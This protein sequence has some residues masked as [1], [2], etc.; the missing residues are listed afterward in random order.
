MF[1]DQSLVPAEAIRLAALGLL[2]E[3]ER[4]YADLAVEVRH[5]VDRVLGPSL[6]SLGPSLELLRYEGLVEA[7]DGPP[8]AGH[9]VDP[10]SRLRLTEAG[11]AMLTTLLAAHVRTPINDVGKLVIA[12][13]LRFLH[14]LE[15]P[16]RGAELDRLAGAIAAERA[17]LADLRTSQAGSET[18]LLA[19]LDREIA[20]AD[21][22]TTWLRSLRQ[23]L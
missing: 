16:A 17:R 14:L 11:G 3:R 1:R 10:A 2:A 21:A 23:Q 5:F 18:Y 9:A 6:D 8:R 4:S 22:R 7:I 15:R 19:W 20:E 12:L 13:K